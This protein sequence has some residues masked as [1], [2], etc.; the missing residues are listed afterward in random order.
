M[1]SE[2]RQPSR[3][4]QAG[5]L[6]DISS[7]RSNAGMRSWLGDI[8]GEATDV[9]IVPG[10]EPPDSARRR[11]CAR[12]N[13]L[14]ETPPTQSVCGQPKRVRATGPEKPAADAQDL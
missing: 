9:I 11:A 1:A 3:K 2:S 6:L 13:G 5:D 14:H 10:R 8:S 12:L 7:G 4:A